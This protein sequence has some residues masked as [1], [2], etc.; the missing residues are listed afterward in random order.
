MKNIKAILFDMDGV[1]FDTERIYLEDWTKV[2]EMYGYKMIKEIYISVMGTGREAVKK[3]FKNQ[4]GQDLPIDKMYIDKDAL[5]FE[6]IENNKIPLKN[7]A[8]EILDFL[9]D[10]GYKIALATSAKRERLEKQLQGACIKEKFDAIV[11]G[12]DVS[13]S[14]PNPEIFLKAAQKLLVEPKDCIVIEDSPAGIKAAYNAG[15]IGFHVEDLKEADTEILKY[16]YKNFKNLLEINEFLAS[17]GVS[18]PT[19]GL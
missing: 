4:F 8:I 19:E 15:M 5:L 6:A 18:T 1:I 9:R 7:G 13:N 10:N 12:D 3:T 2:F 14:K 11:C 16:C 17:G